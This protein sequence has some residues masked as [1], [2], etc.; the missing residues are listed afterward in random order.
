MTKRGSQ[1]NINGNSI[2]RN[3][4]DQMVC[5]IVD[6]QVGRINVT[7]EHGQLRALPLLVEMGI[8]N[9]TFVNTWKNWD[10]LTYN[11]LKIGDLPI[12]DS[13]SSLVQFINQETELIS[14]L[15]TTER[16]L[17]NA[18]SNKEG[19]LI[20]VIDSPSFY[21]KNNQ[22]GKPMIEDWGLSN[23][24]FEFNVL[25]ADYLESLGIDDPPIPL[26][27]TCNLVFHQM[28]KLYRDAQGEEPQRLSTIFDYENM[29]VE[30]YGWHILKSLATREAQLECDKYIYKCLRPWLE[31]DV[32][33]VVN[34][35]LDALQRCNFDPA[36]VENL[37]K[38]HLG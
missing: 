36:K 29:P 33:K 5:V 14:G 15:N 30:S 8:Q 6:P 21:L 7:Q 1:E 17:N 2:K 34:N 11:Y 3:I 10:L 35:I 32:T 18:L 12:T 26:N 9:F 24:C 37:K 22:D 19:N 20:L 25:F 27:Q 4:L 38:V 16:L 13:F 23:S 28:A 31:S